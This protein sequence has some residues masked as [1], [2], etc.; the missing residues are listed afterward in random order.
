[1]LQTLYDR[2]ISYAEHRHAMW[3]LA[4]V[5]FIESSV[6]PIPPDV[7]MIPMILARP[8]AAWRIALVATA[9]SVAGGVAG[10]AIGFHF[11]DQIGAPVLEALG[12]GDKM[13]AFNARFQELGIWAVLVAGVTPFPFKVITI[14][15]GW[16]AMPLLP[17]VASALVARALRF[18]VVAAL[19]RIF[20]APIRDFIE[21]RLGLVF[22]I[23]CV[24]LVGGFL[25]VR[26]L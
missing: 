21:R 12:K 18:F 4:F 13:V 9:A 1:M 3:V 11:Y 17:F 19:L 7:L 22:T 5:A 24:V 23:F 2:T 16:A 26:Y 8:H 6:F 15:S 14:M 25:L 10:Y 20:G